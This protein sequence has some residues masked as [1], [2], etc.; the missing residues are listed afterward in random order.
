MRAVILAAGRGS[1]IA[2]VTRGRPKSLLSFG[3]LALLD[4]QIASLLELGVSA[5]AIV[6]G[7][8]RDQIVDHVVRHHSRAL[9]AVDFVTNR[10]F[11]STNNMY[12][13]WQARPWLGRE[14]F[15]CLN[16]DVL[17]HPEI[18]RPAVEATSDISLVVDREV[19]EETAKVVIRDGRVRALSKTIAPPECDGTFT[20]IATFS[21]RGSRLLF[22]R[23]EAEFLAG[24]VT[25]F[26]NDVI[27]QLAAEGVPIYFTETGG[28]PWTEVD[29]ERDLL[30]ARRETYPQIEA[31][32]CASGFAS[33]RA[34][35]RS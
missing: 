31:L 18:L 24:R 28:L 12:S 30:A 3:G 14:P 9:D 6:V 27:G 33:A 15:V 25:Q 4:R 34:R 2:A 13:L 22:A 11:A 8:E 32:A 20:G 23:A 19:R 21:A 1:R 16:A 26:F 7:Y 35:R 10:A 17:C 5:V 29:D